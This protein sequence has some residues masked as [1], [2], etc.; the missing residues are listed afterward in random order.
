MFS[1]LFVVVAVV[2]LV[3][4]G[5]VGIGMMSTMGDKS[6]AASAAGQP[7]ASAHDGAKDT[8]T[9]ADAARAKDQG[10]TEQGHGTKS[11]TSGGGSA[12]R[13]AGEDAAKGAEAADAAD[14]GSAAD[15]DTDTGKDKSGG[16]S[17]SDAKQDGSETAG[18]GHPRA[19]SAKATPGKNGRIVSFASSRCIDV[20]DG[21]SASGTPLQI[22]TCSNDSW[23]KWTF[24]SDGTV[25]TLGKCMQ[26]AGGSTADGT[27]IVLASCTGGASQKFTLNKAHD[28]VNTPVGKCVD[29]RDKRTA[30]GTRLQLY[31]CAG[32]SN[33]KWGLG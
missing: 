1:R 4:A 26:V 3:A 19:T 12:P 22:W 7:S 31:S 27:S 28:L 30:D 33:Q 17:A 24:Y 32:T 18:T 13:P 15:A 5:A 20:L 23:Q 10:A 2:V 9:Q 16:T 6:G 21:N 14:G 11:V 25:R 29:V 8:R